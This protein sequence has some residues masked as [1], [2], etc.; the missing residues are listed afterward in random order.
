MIIGIDESGT[1]NLKDKNMNFFIGIHLSN[2]IEQRKLKSN[3]R[4]WK[5]KYPKLK[6]NKGEIKGNRITE[7]IADEF[8]KKVIIPQET[9]YITVCG[10]TPALHKKRDIQFNR[11]HHVKCLEEGIWECK[12]IGNIKLADAYK[13]LKNWYRKLSYQLLLK[14]WILGEM[15]G[16]SFVEHVLQV[17]LDEKDKT[18]GVIKIS[19]DKDFVREPRHIIF[20][21]DFLRSQFYNYTY[22]HPVTIVSEWSEDHPFFM[23]KNKNKG[24]LFVDS[25]HVIGRNCNFINSH[26]STEIQVADILATII[27]KYYNKKEFLLVYK[28]IR[29]FFIP[30]RINPVKILKMTSPDEAKPDLI[31]NPYKILKRQERT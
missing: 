3:L 6:N 11:D 15:I 7:N 9:F 21:K 1:F 30:K 13:E 24:E 17:I 25:N 8:I 10:T 12:K 2:F 4:S 22:R 23:A 5:D 18:L 29:N 19:I 31:P 20:W 14:T 28:Q 27:S 16:H 26:N